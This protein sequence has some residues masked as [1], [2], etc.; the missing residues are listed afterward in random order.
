MKKILML[1]LV[2]SLLAVPAFATVKSSNVVGLVSTKLKSIRSRVIS[3]R[4][5]LNVA[6]AKLQDL[7]TKYGTEIDAGDK[8]ALVSIFSDLVDAVD[9]LD[10]LGIN[11]DTSFPTL[12]E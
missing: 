6:K 8:A 4:D 1:A 3:T 12:Q 11:I 9:A 7:N 2:M 5:R 10:T